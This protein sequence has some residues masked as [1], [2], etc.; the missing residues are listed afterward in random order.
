MFRSRWKPGKREIQLHSLG[1]SEIDPT[2]SVAFAM[3]LPLE[4]STPA[5][6]FYYYNATMFKYKTFG[7]NKPFL[8]LDLRKTVSSFSS[9]GNQGGRASLHVPH[10]TPSP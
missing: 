3:P 7:G 9:Y 2:G 6:H 8:L 1:L 4:P 10:R 5:K